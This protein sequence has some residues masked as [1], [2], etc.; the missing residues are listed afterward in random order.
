M[1]FP[2]ESLKETLRHCFPDVQIQQM[3]EIDGKKGELQVH[4][5]EKT[6]VSAREFVELPVRLLSDDG[7]EVRLQAEVH[8]VDRLPIDSLLGN[9][10][11]RPNGVDILASSPINGL[12]ALQVQGHLITLEEP[13]RPIDPPGT[14][15][16]RT[17]IKAAEITPEPAQ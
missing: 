4:G 17:V 8:V 12:P 2:C 14:S 15:R 11:L 1:Y 13:R 16:K 6:P 9:N 3:P 7:K 5:I 10:F